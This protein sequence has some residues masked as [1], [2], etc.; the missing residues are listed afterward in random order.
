MP[1]SHAFILIHV[2]FSTKNRMPFITPKVSPD[3]YSY[4]SSVA[5]N[6]DCECYR[7]GGVGDHVHLAIRLARPLSIADLVEDIKSSSSRW[8]KTQSH[9]L[10]DFSWQKGYGAFSVGPLDRDALCDYID[11]Q[12]QHHR[13]RTFQDEYPGFLQKYEI[14]YD[15]RYLWD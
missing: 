4:L 11:S 10:T 8:I 2:I 14:E 13:K 9:D 12:E 7:V 5:R 15:E 3:L 6:A 1:Q